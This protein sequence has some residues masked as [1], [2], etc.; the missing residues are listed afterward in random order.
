MNLIPN[1]ELFF[2]EKK[3]LVRKSTHE[4]FSGRDVLV[5]GIN[6]AFLPTDEQMVKDYEKLYLHFKDTTLVG[7]PTDPT[8]IDD[9]YFVSLNDPYVMEAWWKKMKIKNCKYLADGS[10]A[11]TLRL[12]QQGGMTPGQTVVEMYNKGYGKRSWRYVLLMENNC[13]MCYVEEETPENVS[14]RD[15]LEGDLYELTKPEEALK[16]LKA[17]QQTAHIGDEN[18][19][20][21]AAAYV[22]LVDLGTDPNN[23][24]SKIKEEKISDR[25]G[26]G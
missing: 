14:T 13:Q 25:M 2:I 3:K 19:A 5:I 15:N 26:L 8:H 11:F 24:P 17:R 23:N 1:A 21:D 10:G 18:A 4:L 16:M 6:G 20:A 22:P 12:D 9:I 7:S